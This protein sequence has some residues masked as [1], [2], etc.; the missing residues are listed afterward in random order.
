MEK[1]NHYPVEKFYQAVYA[2][3]TGPKDV[4]SRLYDAYLCFHPVQADDL[5]LELRK[6]YEWILKKLTKHEPMVQPWNGEIFKGSVEVSLSR[7]KNKTGVEIAKRIVALYERLKQL[8][9][10]EE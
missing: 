9:E 5:P 7:I 3:A 2:L 8:G 1:F 10:A 6:D 4:R